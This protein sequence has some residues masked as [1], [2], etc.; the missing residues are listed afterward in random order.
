[1]VR[2]GLSGGNAADEQKELK[3]TA[4]N[5]LAEI[6]RERYEDYQSRFQPIVEEVAGGLFDTDGYNQKADQNS[7]D[8]GK[9]FSN[10]NN[11]MDRSLSRRGVSLSDAQRKSLDRKRAIN[12]SSAKAG[13]ENMTRQTL[14]D[15]DMNVAQNVINIGRGADAKAQQGLQS[16]A[17]YENQQNVAHTNAIASHN[18]AQM[19]MFGTAAGLTAAIML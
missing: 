2:P 19:Q 6:T 12:E 15:R 14:R 1:M 7:A 4:T 9:A 13:T 5:Q 17:N 10:S 8:V 18:A 16:A 11:Q 3:N